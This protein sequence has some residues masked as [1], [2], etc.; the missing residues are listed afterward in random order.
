MRYKKKRVE[1]GIWERSEEKVDQT[2]ASLDYFE[3]SELG[4]M[5]I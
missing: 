1:R 5:R 3:R 4:E 2:S